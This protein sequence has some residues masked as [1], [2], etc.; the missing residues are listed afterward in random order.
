MYIKAKNKVKFI[1]QC[2]T[3]QPADQV[4]ENEL[5]HDK[6]P[7]HIEISLFICPAQDG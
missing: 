2:P 3:K 1:Q 7:N 6:D 4:G 5:F